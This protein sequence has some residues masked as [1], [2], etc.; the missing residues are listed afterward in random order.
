MG[1][2]LKMSD[3]RPPSEIRQ[4]E[5]RMKENADLVRRM[6]D[7]QSLSRIPQSATFFPPRPVI[8]KDKEAQNRLYHSL[9]D[10]K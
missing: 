7:G 5:R 10:E 3:S 9:L 2:V 8:E 4:I 6:K 1:K